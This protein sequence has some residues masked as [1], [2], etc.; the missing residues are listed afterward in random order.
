MYTK[1]ELK[2]KLVAWLVAITMIFT[3]FAVPAEHMVSYGESVKIMN[4]T[5]EGEPVCGQTLTAKVTGEGDQEPTNI[6]YQWKYYEEEYDELE[7]YYVTVDKNLEGK[8]EKTLF[9]TDDLA[10]KTIGVEVSGE[11]IKK[12]SAKKVKIKEQSNPDK[13]YIK[14]LISD[15]PYAPLSPKY[16]TDE[17]VI[18]VVKSAFERKHQ[19]DSEYPDVKIKVLSSSIESVI[20]SDGKINYFDKD[21]SKVTRRGIYNPNV[22]DTTFSGNYYQPEVTFELAKGSEKV[23]F[24]KKFNVYWNTEKL[25]DSIRQNVLDPITEDMVKGENS[26]LDN[27]SKNIVLKG[28]PEHGK[29]VTLSWKTD[30]NDI[31]EVQKTGSLYEPEYMLVPHPSENDQTVILTASVEGYNFVNDGTQEASEIKKLSKDF[32]LTV[33]GTGVSKAQ[34]MAKAEKALKENYTVDKL[35]YADIEE[36]C[37]PSHVKGDLKLLRLKETGI[38]DYSEYKPPVVTSDSENI[39]VNGYRASVV[40]PLYGQEAEKAVLTVKMVK[41]SDPDFVISTK[42]NITIEPLGENDIKN[43]KALMEK[44]KESYF[45]GIRGENTDKNSIDKNLKSFKEVYADDSQ[46]LVWIQNEDERKNI[47][48]IPVELPGYDPMVNDTFRLFRSSRPS[49]IKH[50]NLILVQKPEYD[51]KVQIDGRISVYPYRNYLNVYKDNEDIKSLINQPVNVTVCVKGEKGE[52]PNAGQ[53]EKEINVNAVVFD[54]KTQS[55]MPPFGELNVKSGFAKS[56]GFGGT[57]VEECAIEGKVTALDVLSKYFAKK[58]GLNEPFSSEDKEKIKRELVVDSNGWV[59]KAGTIDGNN[60]TFFVNDSMPHDGTFFDAKKETYNG[61]LINNSIIN[62]GDIVTFYGVK[63]GYGTANP[64][65][66]TWFESEGKKVTTLNV[67]KGE[68]ISITIK[69]YPSTFGLNITSIIER[70]TRPIKGAE[71]QVY[72]N[73]TGRITE[74]NVVSNNEGVFSFS[75]DEEK[76]YLITAAGSES[77]NMVAPILKV[78]ITEAVASGDKEKIVDDDLAAL[79]FDDIKGENSGESEIVKNLNLINTGKSGKTSIKW[80]SDQNA[81]IG[82]DGTVVRP[83]HEQGDKNVILT[84]TVSYGD[85]SKTK[86]IQVTVKKLDSSAE[87]LDKIISRLEKSITPKEYDDSNIKNQDTNIIEYVRKKVQEINSTANVGNTCTPSPSQTQIKE[88]GSII[89]GSKRVSGN[90]DFEIILGA[91]SKKYT[92]NVVVGKKLPTKAE[93]LAGDWLTFDKIKG[94]NKSVD[95]VTEELLLPKEENKYYTALEWTSS[96]PETVKIGEYAVSGVYKAAVVRPSSSQGD[97]EVV[98]TCTIKPGPYWQ[99]MAPAGAMPEPAYGIKK[100]T[101]KVK[102]PTKEEEGQAESLLAESIKLFDL[103]NMTLRGTRDKLDLQNITYHFN[104]HP[105]NWNY[106]K[107]NPGYRNEFSA[108]QINWKSENPGILKLGGACD[109]K[110]TGKDQRGDIVLTLSYN[111]AQL[112]KRWQTVVKAMGQAEMTEIN[113]LTKEFAD[114]LSFE[115]IKKENKKQ[116]E[117]NSDLALI[118]SGTKDNG[119]LKFSTKK[120]YHKDGVNIV[121]ES[122]NTALLEIPSYGNTIKIKKRPEKNTKIT[123]TATVKPIKFDY[124]EGF[125]IY[126][127]KI[128]V[129]VPGTNDEPPTEDMVSTQQA[130]L[131]K[132]SVAEGRKLLGTIYNIYVAKDANWWGQEAKFWHMVLVAAYARDID[133][134]ESGLEEEKKQAFADARIKELE[135]LTFDKNKASVEANVLANA[136][137][138]LSAA[139]YDP[140]NITDSSGKNINAAALLAG[141]SLSDATKGWYSTI[142]PYALKAFNQTAF[143]SENTEKEYILYLKDELQK[144]N[145]S[146]GVD[147]PAMII[148]GLAPYYGK[149][150]DITKATDDALLK[151]SEAQ[152]E[153]GSMG[154]ANS[155]AMVLITLAGLG[156]NADKDA[157]F[158]KAK[159]SLLSGILDHVCESGDG[160]KNG[161]KNSFNDMATYQGGIGLISAIKVLEAGKPYDVFDFSNMEK[162]PVKYSNSNQTTTGE[163]NPAQP[164]VQEEKDQIKVSFEFVG[165][166]KHGEGGAKNPTVWIPK[167]TVT[168]PKGS[169]VKYLTD[170]ELQKAGLNFETKKKGGYISKVQIPNSTDYLGEFDNGPN[171]GWMYRHNGKIADEGYSDRTLSD[172]DKIKW[173]YTDDYIKEKGYEGNWDRK[174]AAISEE[175]KKDTTKLQDEK[176]QGKVESNAKL[177]GV[178]GVAKASIEKSDIDGKLK[179][180]EQKAS[181]LRKEGKGAVPKELTIDVKSGKDARIVETALKRD[182]LEKLGDNVDSLVINTDKGSIS[183]DKKAVNSLSKNGKQEVQITIS[184]KEM[185]EDRIAKIDTKEKAKAANRPVFRAEVKQDGKTVSDIIGNISMRIVYEKNPTENEEAIVLYK[186]EQDGTLSI[187]KDA[188][189]D[190]GLIQVDGTELSEDLVLGYNPKKFADTATHWAYKNIEFLAAREIIRGKSE[191]E[192]DPQGI[193]SRAEFAQILAALSGEDLDKYN[194]SEFSDTDK[195]S[196]YAKSVA[197]AKEK[198]IINGNGDGTFAPNNPITRQDMAVMI[199]RYMKIADKKPVENYEAVAFNDIKTVSPYAKNA[200]NHMQKTGII[201]GAASNG[202]YMFNPLKNATRA[203][204]AVMI[205]KYIKN[206]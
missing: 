11:G 181:E 67:P 99:F 2:E 35:K 192:F 61:T 47:G 176:L 138:G 57:N 52:N 43:A 172:N 121:W 86:S 22:S 21:V 33:K 202:G 92:A 117:I 13:D 126:N 53:V 140:Q 143:N 9:L 97:K 122:S 8:T 203:E 132:D 42:L 70:N 111:G 174:N 135:E 14:R 109:I 65:I 110:R 54:V 179:E 167:R 162:K 145:Y 32:T 107:R 151:I 62:D 187:I 180:M 115:N 46:N 150:S 87:E 102:A 114:S 149:E 93:A 123:L 130:N 168:I 82:K 134:T 199:E 88:N 36:E 161:S 157:A 25:K 127:K 112:E 154:N 98:L 200:V 164:P 148:Q 95:T 158:T 198:G 60:F 40:R 68:N 24:Q 133:K 41:K 29:Y 175:I 94:K 141:I 108:I 56:I 27:I 83:L 38:E 71:L 206:L 3:G 73:A 173:F 128:E 183:L 104:D 19:N 170:R 44:V 144:A 166:T 23:A 74:K 101:I 90:V 58:L 91:V 16:G 77:L 89:Y 147:V 169:T 137:N 125:D 105:L 153:N 72:D 63:N 28:R 152:G 171:S 184:K 45:D 6:T 17:N 37:N 85:I 5:I 100:I 190:K 124:A 160:F 1:R 80:E 18:D 64:D 39:T 69:G 194:A 188:V 131:Q 50:E 103:S 201:N 79:S 139:G 165:D 76:E 193:I 49:I 78:K 163:E 189:Y 66:F 20:E 178:T 26:S 129:V 136:I 119:E 205:T 75:L 48:I 196:W 191:K 113:G 81:I 120:E 4:V 12:E 159:G 142:A 34:L 51:T 155:D 182:V 197:W 55:I 177:D 204:A 31:I 146:W 156:K 84:A 186:V 30:K 96:D 106:V 118:Q 116:I 7:E 10:N 59:K 185:N 15:L 195:N